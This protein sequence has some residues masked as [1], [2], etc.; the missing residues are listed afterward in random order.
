MVARK[1]AVDYIAE[2]K[3]ARYNE[4]LSIFEERKKNAPKPERKPR[5]PMTNEQKVKMTR[6]RIE[7]LKAK[8]AALEADGE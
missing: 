8:L 2:D 6:G 7:K 1:T 5:A 4:L 3:F